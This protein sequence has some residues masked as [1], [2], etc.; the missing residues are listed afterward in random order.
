MN[1]SESFMKINEF[2]DKIWTTNDGVLHRLDRPAVEYNGGSE[3]WWMDGFRHRS[4]GPAVFFQTDIKNGTLK[5]CVIAKMVR[6]LFIQK[7]IKNGLL[8]MFFIKQKKNILMLFQ[9]KQK[10]GV[11]LA[12]IS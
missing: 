8:T 7:E 10:Q 6:Q 1:E 2:G 12:R 4:D 9:T 5:V 3:T 11:Y